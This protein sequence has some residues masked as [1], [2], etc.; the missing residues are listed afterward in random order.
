MKT[1][2]ILTIAL[3]I[4][5]LQCAVKAQV[6]K[7]W[8]ARYNGSFQPEVEADKSGNIFVIGCTS[9]FGNYATIKYDTHGAEQWVNIYNGSGSSQDR[10]QDHAVDDSGNVYVTGYSSETGRGTDM[11]TI[12]Y[13]SSG[14]Q[15]WIVS[16]N[17]TDSL[18][19]A[20]Y[21]IALDLSGNVYVTGF[22]ARS[23]GYNY[24]TIKYNSSGAEQ[25][26]AVYANG[27]SNN[28]SVAVDLSGNVFV[29]GS[30][31][32][33]YVTIKYNPSGTEQWAMKYGISGL[34][35]HANSIVLDKSGNAF[36]TGY[37]GSLGTGSDY[38]T[39][40]YNSSGAAQWTLRY[41]GSGN[42]TDIAKALVID[43]SDNVYV[44]GSSYGSGTNADYA[45][46]K[47]NSSGSVQWVK[48]Y[49][50]SYNSYNSTDEA[51]SIALDSAGNIY[52][53]GF[54]KETGTF[55]DYT[56][57]KYNSSGDQLWIVKYNSLGAFSDKATSMVLDPTG[58]IIIT[59]N[60][61]GDLTTLKY[62]QPLSI[63]FT[64]LI[65]GLYN[66]ITNKMMKD[67]VTVFLRNSSSPF[68][69]VDSSKGIL[70]SNGKGKFYFRNGFNN[71]P[72]YLCVD[73]R[74]SIETWSSVPVSFT[75]N[76]AVFDFTSSASQAFGDNQALVG[77]KYCIYNGD[78]DRNGV[79]DSRDMRAVDNDAFNSVSGHVLTDLTG[80]GYVDGSDLSVVDNNT[81]NF[82][83]TIS[84]QAQSNNLRDESQ[85]EEKSNTN[86]QAK[87]E[88]N[89]PN[90][91]NPSTS[92][93]FE[94]PVS[95]FVKLRV[96]D[97]T[98]REVAT[99]INKEMQSGIH[100]VSFNASNLSTGVYYYKLETGSYSEIKKMTL[101]K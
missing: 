89:Y 94:I 9:N 14:V 57:I 61:G 1:I 29:T 30:S 39:I 66:S 32:S 26:V 101:I 75:F 54:T 43:D 87:L 79:I 19:D 83:T 7:Q 16:Y 73:H 96:Y 28:P 15:R 35:D 84:P 65:Q 91:F 55:E 97:L 36:V 78:I 69:M 45:T 53:S 6:D 63:D 2:K 72:Y 44:T 51:N 40:K 27:S 67:T 31:S 74:N 33:D 93:N 58:N 5:L 59:G 17:G 95:S 8:E 98:G 77:A 85:T 99:L 80:D 70:D 47:Y 38:A 22:S 18:N 12:K 62:T 24:V 76:E 92:I 50:G 56:T 100:S 10:P 82:I 13:S 71:M 49:N 21:S 46:I 52:V 88:Q 90:P 37:S 68:S 42:S 3:S 20:A 34:T 64:A 86:E 81:F 23:G 41:G 11:T 25:W 60:S 4:L 48:R